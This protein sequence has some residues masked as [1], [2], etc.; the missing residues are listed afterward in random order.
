MYRERVRGSHEFAPRLNSI[1]FLQNHQYCLAAE[2]EGVEGEGWVRRRVRGWV[3]GGV[4]K[5][6]HECIYACMHMRGNIGM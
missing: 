5:R 1:V 2:E 6:I 3:R 4:S